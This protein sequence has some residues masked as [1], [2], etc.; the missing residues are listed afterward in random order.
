MSRRS[1]LEHDHVVGRSMKDFGARGALAWLRTSPSVPTTE[2]A[3]A[4]TSRFKQRLNS[5]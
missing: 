3:E 2:L 4:F 5:A 1:G